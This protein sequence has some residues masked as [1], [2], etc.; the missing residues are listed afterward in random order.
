M[1]SALVRLF[2]CS[3]A[4]IVGAPVG[5]NQVYRFPLDQDNYRFGSGHEWTRLTVKGRQVKLLYAVDLGM[6]RWLDHPVSE[7]E[8]CDGRG[9]V[10]T[11]CQHV[12]GDRVRLP[13]NRP[14]AEVFFRIRF[15]MGGTVHW[16]SFQLPSTLAP[17]ETK[18][19][20]SVYKL[21]LNPWGKS[22][23]PEGADVVVTRRRVAVMVWSEFPGWPAIL[24]TALRL[25]SRA[26]FERRACQTFSG[27]SAQIPAGSVIQT[28]VVDLRYDTASGVQRR[29]FQ[30][31]AHTQPDRIKGDHATYHLPFPDRAYPLGAVGWI[32][33]TVTGRRVAILHTTLQTSLFTTTGRDHPVLAIQVCLKGTSNCQMHSGDSIELPP[34]IPLQDFHFMIRY[35]ERGVVIIQDFLLPIT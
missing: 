27:N 18:E 10:P 17:D 31:A 33:L 35:I 11:D 26:G 6:G 24:P 3:L 20:Q 13:A 5:A 29:S 22:V 19:D 21:C 15:T 12:D 28:F 8:L 7:T 25:C 2:A 16:R 34:A 23:P 32:R 4:W 14:L 30:I 1:K 9:V